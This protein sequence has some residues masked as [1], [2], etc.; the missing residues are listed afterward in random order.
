[1]PLTSICVYSGSS[2]GARPAYSEAARSL[3]RELALRGIRLVYGGGSVG[4][5]NEVAESA[6]SAGGE[7]WGVIPESLTGK[8]LQHMGLTK[9]FV[10]RSMHE[11]KQTMID[12]AD[13]FIALP[14]GLGT[15]DEMFEVL[16][17]GQLSFHVKPCGFLNVDAYYDPLLAFL[18]HAVTERFI[19]PDHRAMILTADSPAALL[20]R[21][22]D[23]QPPNLEKWIRE[24][25]PPAP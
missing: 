21:F 13:A 8:N 5:M 14:G 1:M 3:G 2:R 20:A 23:Y 19:S 9:T 18:D 7:V 6:L 17:W 4:L 22:A 16:T 10:T 12:L 25:T 15:L 24:L 11:R